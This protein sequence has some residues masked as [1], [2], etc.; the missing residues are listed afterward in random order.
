[1]EQFFTHK[2]PYTDFHELN[3][4]WILS[5][6]KK[7][8]DRM[9]SLQ[10]T[11]LNLANSYTD[12]Q[13]NKLSENLTAQFQDFQASVNGQM[14]SLTS[15]VNRQ[16]EEQ[17]KELDAVTL[18]LKNNIDN[19]NTQFNDFVNQILSEIDNFEYNTNIRIDGLKKE[20]VSEI[21]VDFDNI[22]VINFFTGE[23]VSV[24]AM[25]DYLA[26]LHITNPLTYD[27]I[28]NKD[29][30]YT[31]IGAYNITYTQLVTDGNRLIQ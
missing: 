3:L 8:E 20:I 10:E 27:G 12:E 24:Q 30:T 14:A 19:L 9:N 31:Q 11:I 1:M 15:S 16:I 5:E 18:S 4:D 21:S 26:S 6:I 28:A 22:K 2:Y 7:L 23:E 17:N 29:K 25:F 13:I